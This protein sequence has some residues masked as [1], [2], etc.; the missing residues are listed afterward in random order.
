MKTDVIALGQPIASERVRIEPRKRSTHSFGRLGPYRTLG[1]LLH[2]A[3]G[4][5]RRGM[6]RARA[7]ATRT[8]AAADAS[9]AKH[10]GQSARFPRT[11]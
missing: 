7:R 9:T 3:S 8:S 5:E 1:D 4:T 2:R 10:C 11:A 6:A